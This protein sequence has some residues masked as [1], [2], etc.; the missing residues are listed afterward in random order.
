MYFHFSGCISRSRI[1]RSRDNSTFN[2][3]SNWQTVF[4]G[5]CTIVPSHYWY[6]RFSSF[7]TS[8]PICMVFHLF[9]FLF[10]FFLPG[11]GVFFR[12][13]LTAYRSSQARGQIGAPAASLRH[14]NAGS[15]LCLRPTPQLTTTLDH[16]P[17]EQGQGLNPHP[18][19]WDQTCSSLL[20]HSRN[21]PS[22]LL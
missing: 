16:Q 19:P 21:S 13:A 1:T 9:S 6:L 4:W 8:S 10:S 18:N 3:L 11:G 15:E 5:T 17:T 7:S 12:A 20:S 2:I 14:S 22:F